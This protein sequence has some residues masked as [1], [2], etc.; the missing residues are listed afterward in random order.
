MKCQYVWL[1]LTSTF[2]LP[3][4]VIPLNGI[5][6]SIFFFCLYSRR[7]I[8][9][10]EI[11]M[12]YIALLFPFSYVYIDFYAI[13]CIFF[14]LPTKKKKKE[15]IWRI[16]ESERI[17]HSHPTR[18]W[19]I[20]LSG[21]DVN[22]NEYYKMNAV[23]MRYAVCARYI[24]LIIII[25]I[26]CGLA[27]L[28]LR[29]AQNVWASASDSVRVKYFE[30]YVCKDLDLLSNLFGRK[31]CFLI[32]NTL[33]RKKANKQRF[34]FYFQMLNQICINRQ[35]IRMERPTKIFKSVAIESEKE[36]TSKSMRSKTCTQMKTKM[37]KK[38]SANSRQPH[39]D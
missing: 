21:R 4:W 33:E 31:W 22:K 39:K 24:A 9:W 37:K 36:I 12:Q 1:G 38:K 11:L 27:T 2:V 19:R 6:T 26:I 20:C 3:R 30:T 23:C 35:I 29:W 15:P 18:V 13:S 7:K 14:S 28:F 16:L 25:I 8:S 34:C 17:S 5:S 32:I 10:Y